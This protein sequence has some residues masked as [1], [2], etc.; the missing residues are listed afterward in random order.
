MPLRSLFPNNA[1][2]ICL[3]GHWYRLVVS[4]VWSC[5]FLSACVCGALGSVAQTERVAELLNDWNKPDAPGLV[6]AAVSNGKIIGSGMFGLADL[7]RGTPITLTTRFNIGSMSKQFTALAVLE[8]AAQKKLSLDDEIHRYVPELPDFG[9]QI[10]LRHLIHHT[11]GLQDWD[12]IIHLAG[13]RLEDVITHPEVLRLICGRKTLNF[14]PGDKFGY[15]NSG[16]SLLATVVERITGE[17]FAPWMRAHIFH[18][19]GLDEM[20]VQDKADPEMPQRAESYLA[21]GTGS[22]RHIPDKTAILG[23]SSIYCSMNEFVKYLQAF[24][25]SARA[26]SLSRLEGKGTFNGGAPNPYACGVYIGEHKGLR[27][28]SHEGGWAGFPTF[29]LRIPEK[30]L[31]VALFANHGSIEPASLVSQIADIY[32]GLD[33][34]LPPPTKRREIALDAATLD[35]YAGEYALAPGLLISITREG[36]HLM[37]EAT[38]HPRE[39]M[40]AEST[41]TFFFKVENS[42][43]RFVSDEKGAVTHLV[44]NRQG[45]TMEAKRLVFP[46]L[47]ADALGDYAGDYRNE[48]LGSQFSVRAKAGRL[49]AWHPRH[50]EIALM[51]T[52]V[53]GFNGDEWWLGQLSF[54]RND[55]NRVNAFE[56]HGSRIRPVKFTKMVPE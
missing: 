49:V 41:E 50:G 40:F 37:S 17:N 25:D 27:S 53:D 14:S 24:D 39:R 33:T 31:G 55:E 7:E 47:S 45:R 9:A 34:V 15:T 54:Q 29:M 51:P 18:P 56:V 6:W 48:E 3:S 19:L 2:R 4:L 35:R 30:K 42:T 21:A 36:D 43:I 52:G 28:I 16:Y 8:L 12:Q 44:L 13:V 10:S 32:L 1:G 20:S 22:F 5:G 26:P 11:S 23:A 46:P 38:G